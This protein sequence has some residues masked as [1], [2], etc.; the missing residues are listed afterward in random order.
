MG[1]SSQSAFRIVLIGV[2]AATVLLALK[3]WRFGEGL[4]SPRCNIAYPGV[5]GSVL[6]RP[7]V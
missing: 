2:F 5:A 4:A 6:V 7:A 3:T 1:R